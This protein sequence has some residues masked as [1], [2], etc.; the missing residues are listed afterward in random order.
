MAVIYGRRRLGKTQLVQHSLRDRDDAVV[1]Q[2]T[3]TTAQLQLDEFVDVAAETF[4][5]ITNI[6]RDWEALLG[7]L[8]DQNAVVV[9]DEFPYLID[10]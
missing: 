5:G 2:G 3:E 9:L 7:Y 4:P 1:Y 8:G 6:K 10:A